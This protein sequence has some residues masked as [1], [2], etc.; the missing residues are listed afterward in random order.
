MPVVDEGLIR[1]ADQLDVAFA[2]VILSGEPV[3]SAVVAAPVGIVEV[4]DGEDAVA[5]G[6]MVPRLFI[7]FIS[8]FSG[9][10]ASGRR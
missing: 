5:K 10:V 2:G 4:P 8:R 3:H 7:S 6:R 1:N 9:V